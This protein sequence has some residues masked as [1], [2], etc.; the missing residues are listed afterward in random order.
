MGY[1]V[2]LIAVSGRDPGSIHSDYG[3]ASTGRREW[4]P[5]SP[6]V[7]AKLR[8]GIYLLY[9]NDEIVPDDQ[10]FA[11]LS[12]NA[13]LVACY[14]NET[15]MSSYACAWTKGVQRWSVFH[16]AEQ[17]IQHLEVTGTLP[18][19]FQSIRDRLLAQ[20]SV[21]GDADYT[22]DIPV[23]LFVALGGVRYNSEIPGA[24]P[25]P[26]EILDRRGRG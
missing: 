20:Q 15:V 6:V 14:A 8:G 21:S 19:E 4:V 10:V 26:W 3:V 13:S 24:G 12:G 25:Q 9:I 5:E 18:D 2:Q 7:G 16:D 1:R 22:F 17:G 23:E 11:R